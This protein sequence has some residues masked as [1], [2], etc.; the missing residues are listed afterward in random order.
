IDR[1]AHIRH[2][3]FEVT[4]IVKVRVSKALIRQQH[5]R[6]TVYD[7]VD[8][9]LSIFEPV[10]K[11]LDFVC[12]SK[13]KIMDSQRDFHAGQF[14]YESYELCNVD[15]GADIEVGICVTDEEFEQLPSRPAC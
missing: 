13:R 8:K 12:D 4:L 6:P 1:F 5:C 3:F 15:A 14:A 9:Y 10:T 7:V 2:K 11:R